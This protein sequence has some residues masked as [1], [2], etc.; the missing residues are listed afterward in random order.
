[1]KTLFNY[2]HPLENLRRKRV[3]FNSKSTLPDVIQAVIN[4]PCP[5]VS[6]LVK[7]LDFI[8][9]DLETTGF[10]STKD[11]ILSM[12]WVGINKGYVDL[13]SSVHLYI[14][15][16][17]HVKAETAVINHIT[18]EMLSQGVSIDDAMR[19][20]FADAKGKILVAHGCVMEKKFIDHYLLKTYGINEIP[21]LW[22]DTLRIEKKL[23]NAINHDDSVD[24]TLSATRERYHLPEYNGHNA[25]AD[26]ISSGE[27]LLVQG[28]RIDHVSRLT[29]GQ[30]YK[31]SL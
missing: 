8:V 27:L 16:D 11:I 2:F 3:G 7:D 13:N 6:T 12:G 28:K 29:I 26:A 25:L 31:M 19:R 18:P 1:M 24:L 9:L 30:L 5:E 17:L 15:N 21:L 20:F 14:N 22:V 4:A 10:D 23:A